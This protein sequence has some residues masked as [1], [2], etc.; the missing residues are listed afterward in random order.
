MESCRAPE[1]R[2]IMMNLERGYDGNNEG[3][4][5]AYELFEGGTFRGEGT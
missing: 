1:K 3:K 5:R 4:L 2:Q